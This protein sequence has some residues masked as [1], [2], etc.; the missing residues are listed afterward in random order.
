MQSTLIS[1]LDPSPSIILCTLP[2]LTGTVLLVGIFISWHFVCLSVFLQSS[3]CASEH[4]V[5]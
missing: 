2:D 5:K 1:Q 4:G 3:V